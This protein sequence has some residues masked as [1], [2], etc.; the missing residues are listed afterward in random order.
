MIDFGVLLF[1]FLFVLLFRL[2]MGEAQ[3][4]IDM[5]E[6]TLEVGMGTFIL[7]SSF[8]PLLFAGLKSIYDCDDIDKS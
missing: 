3:N 7:S 6:G 8:Y 4:N 1:I 2:S 5:D